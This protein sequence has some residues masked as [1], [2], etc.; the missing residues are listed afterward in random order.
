MTPLTHRFALSVAVAIVAAAPAAAAQ[1]V[2][3]EPAPAGA[4]TSWYVV[5]VGDDTLAREM[6][7][8]SPDRLNGELRVLRPQPATLQYTLFTRPDR[9]A[10][11][12]RSTVVSGDAS[13]RTAIDFAGDSAFLAMHSPGAP[14]R[15]DRVAVAAGAL[16]FINLS[17]GIL[18]QVFRRARAVGG[19]EVTVP[20]L[21]GLQ[22][23]PGRVRF[24]GADS[25]V[26]QLNVELRAA[27][28]ADGALHAAVVPAQGVR[29][30]RASRMAFDTP[31]PAA[32]AGNPHA[33]PAGAPYTA[34]DVVVR[35]PAGLA[36]AGTLTLPRGATRAR[37]APVVVTIS[38]SGPQNRDSELAGVRG[39]A[40]FRQVADTLGRRGIGVLR[41]D[42]RG[43]GG[44]EPGPSGVTSAD[45]ADD[46]RAAVAWLR[47][48]PDVDARRIGLLG[49]SEGAMIAPMVAADDT[50]VAAVA[51]LAAPARPGRE[52]SAHQR[53]LAIA[54]SSV[55]LL[56]RDSVF[57]AAQAQSD[58]LV[59][60]GG[61]DAWTRFWWDYDPRPAAARLRVPVLILHGE[62]DMQVPVAHAEELAAAI[63]EGRGAEVT[64]RRYP[65][66]NHLF[67]DDAA[68][69]W[70]GY[71]TL[72]SKLVPPVIMGTLA[73]WFATRLAVPARR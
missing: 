26:L 66:V 57:R 22:S 2:A 37:P 69:H 18:D 39:Y 73:D 71:A 24:I 60:H 5:T 62:T 42:D 38:G 46:V 31:R 17:A 15:H 49:H 53:R 50:L 9:A 29:F 65:A 54:A 27:V 1:R 20:L 44:S 16:P 13:A 72:P 12:L 68:G 21:A 7:V 14:P 51:L 70:G 25:A 36:L 33:A 32:P 56:A 52:V 3:K 43:T 48:Q 55:P 11:S 28:S 45:F 47:G 35:T 61:T 40:I 34:R 4:D 23:M 63:R 10:D 59:L 30:A 67:L 58:S 8:R 41:L 64:L 6:T 19:A